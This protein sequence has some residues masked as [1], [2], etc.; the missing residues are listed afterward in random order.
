MSVYVPA[1]NVFTREVSSF[2]IILTEIF[3]KMGSE[4]IGGCCCPQWDFLSG[5]LTYAVH[6]GTGMIL[7]V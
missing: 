5:V 1:A 3:L 6:R 7:E 2:D 4:R